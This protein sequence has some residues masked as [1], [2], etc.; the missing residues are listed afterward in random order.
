MIELHARRL[1]PAAARVAGDVAEVE[2]LLGHAPGRA[3]G[4]DVA[5]ADLGQ[6][7]VDADEL[8]ELGR[9]GIDHRHASTPWCA[10]GCASLQQLANTVGSYMITAA[11]DKPC[12]G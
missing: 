5:G 10:A 9:V 12:S 11:G 3:L 6:L 1:G 2:G 4:E 8:L 7:G